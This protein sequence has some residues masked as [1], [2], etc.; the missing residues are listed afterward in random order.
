MKSCSRLIAVLALALPLLLS[1]CRFTT[2]KLPVPK[3]P[4]VT[5]VVA[6]EELVSQLNQ[7]WSGFESLTAKVEIQASQ[8]K[9]KEGLA[10]DY[11]T[12]PGFILMRKP[13][14][15][16]V[17]GQV[18]VLGTKMFDYANDDKDFTLFLPSKNKA[19]KGSNSLKKK[20]ANW[21]ENLRPGFF[22]D[23]MAVRGLEPDD[24]YSVTADS[25]TDEDSARKHFFVVPRY[26]LSISRRKPDT[27]QLTPV[28]VV[29]FHRDDLLPYQ[30]DLYD[31]DGNLETQVKYFSYQNFGAI[32][33]PSRVVI[34]RPL[35]ELRIVLTVERVDENMI[36]KDDQFHIQIPE[37]TVI[38][39]QNLE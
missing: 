16:H 23:A 4:L 3:E 22:F 9:A 29:Y 19:F 6:P 39:N 36:L 27:Q 26:I 32:K 5:Q 12:F 31:N 37:G 2:R 28:R 38:Q 13:G 10:T 33:Y 24:L 14:L 1:G 20:S 34:E 30:Q 17:V 15:L 8:L 21:I 18:P 7:R 25:I 11:T 35:E